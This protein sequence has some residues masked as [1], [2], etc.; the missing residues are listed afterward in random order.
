[1]AIAT[2]IRQA[3]SEAVQKR[4][5]QGVHPYEMTQAQY[6]DER[7]RRETKQ[8]ERAI[9]SEK[10]YLEQIKDKARPKEK[11]K[12]QWK[13]EMWE[14]QLTRLKSGEWKRVNTNYLGE[15]YAKMVKKAISTGQPVPQHVINQAP[16]FKAAQTARERYEKGWKTSFANRSSNQR[17]DERGTRL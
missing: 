6:V 12:M 14:K 7:V 11:E 9:E 13:I 3:M 10:G 8:Y 15:Q 5:S 16:Q 1:M 4:Q 17:S 2:E